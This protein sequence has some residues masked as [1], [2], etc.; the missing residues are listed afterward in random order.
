MVICNNNVTFYLIDQ[1]RPE[2]HHLE[3]NYSG[4]YMG[5]RL[6]YL[7]TE[8]GVPARWSVCLRNPTPGS[9]NVSIESI[10]LEDSIEMARWSIEYNLYLPLALL[11]TIWMALGTPLLII[12]RKRIRSQEFMIGLLL[13]IIGVSIG[14]V[15]ATVVPLSLFSPSFIAVFLIIPLILLFRN[16]QKQVPEEPAIDIA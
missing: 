10:S 15:L 14:L 1:N 11:F 2:T 5:I 3:A 16:Q 4:E 13:T 9:L 8:T 7:Y 12:H 6:P